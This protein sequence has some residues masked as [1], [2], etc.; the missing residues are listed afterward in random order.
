MNTNSGVLP[1]GNGDSAASFVS[2]G[3]ASTQVEESK[4]GPGTLQE[5]GKEIDQRTRFGGGKIIQKREDIIIF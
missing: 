3:N 4:L 5:E 1:N 2:S